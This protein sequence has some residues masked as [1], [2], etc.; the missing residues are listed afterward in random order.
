MPLS[1]ASPSQSPY[2]PAFVFPLCGPCRENIKPS[3]VETALE[4]DAILFHIFSI[5]SIETGLV[6]NTV[7]VEMSIK[8][9]LDFDFTIQG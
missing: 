4:F 9:A 8:K 5:R 2:L 1:L 7:P 6:G 3:D